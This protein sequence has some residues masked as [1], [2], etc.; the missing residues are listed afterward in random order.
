MSEAQGDKSTAKWSDDGQTI[1]VNSV[2]TFDN[3]KTAH[4]FDT[5]FKKTPDIKVSE[6]WKLINNGKSISV[7]VNSIS[8]T[9]KNTMNLVYDKQWAVD[10]RF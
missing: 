8:N 6:V 1:I 9:G 4:I 7:E 5:N 3:G 2:R 10:Y